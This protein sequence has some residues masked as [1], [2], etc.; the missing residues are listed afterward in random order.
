MQ[1]SVE[2]LTFAA[3]PIYR[4]IICGRIVSTQPVGDGT[5]HC[6]ACESRP[7]ATEFEV[8]P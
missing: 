6:S 2:E 5:Q 7:P 1:Q 8:V 3:L 4:H